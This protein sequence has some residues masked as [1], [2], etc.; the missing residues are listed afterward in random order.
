MNNILKIIANQTLKLGKVKHLKINIK[1]L[2]EEC[3]RKAM[4]TAENEFNKM[5]IDIEQYKESLDHT[6]NLGR[7][8][9]LEFQN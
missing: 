4:K 2:H 8:L 3:V 5:L 7:L 9:P 6:A 1:E